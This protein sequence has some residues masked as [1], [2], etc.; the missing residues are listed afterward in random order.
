LANRYRAR[1]LLCAWVAEWNKG[2]VFAGW[3]GIK[4]VHEEHPQAEGFVVIIE[5]RLGD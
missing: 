4:H 3:D 2:P 1:C 5:K